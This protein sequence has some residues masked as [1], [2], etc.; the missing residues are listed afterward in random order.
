MFAYNACMY[1]YMCG[2]SACMDVIHALYV[3]YVCVC[4]V[5]MYA[6]YYM[7]VCMLGYVCMF[8]YV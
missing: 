5:F 7:C 8:W 6:Y 3:Y 1:V 2:M 4:G